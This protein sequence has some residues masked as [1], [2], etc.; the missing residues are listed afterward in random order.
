M[1]D[2]V[3]YQKIPRFSREIKITEK[4]DGTNAQILIQL[5]NDKTSII[6]S[7]KEREWPLIK[8]GR[9]LF[10]ITPGSR[11]RWITIKKDNY[12]FAK[13]VFENQEDLFNLGPGRHFGEW[14]GQGIQR[15]YSL[16][17]KRFSL[18]NVERWNPFNC[19]KCCHIVPVLHNGEFTTF[20]IDSALRILRLNGSYASPNFMDPEGIVIFHSAS[21]TLFKKTIKNDEKPKS[22][23]EKDV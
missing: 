12:G 11:N 9:F 6:E 21:G 20:N 17:E 7:F 15:K 8:E 22:Q 1:E 14:W 19:P 3:K 2:F 5:L 18:F 10:G 13:W 4:I 16:D 23:G